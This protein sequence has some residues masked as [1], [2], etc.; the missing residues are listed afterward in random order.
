MILKIKDAENIIYGTMKMTYQFRV[1]SIGHYSM[2]DHTLKN[3]CHSLSMVWKKGVSYG[4]EKRSFACPPKYYSNLNVTCQLKM[5]DH[6]LGYPL[7]KGENLKD[8]TSHY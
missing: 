8:I 7:G 5:T 2:L 6:N 3:D 1:E 4:M